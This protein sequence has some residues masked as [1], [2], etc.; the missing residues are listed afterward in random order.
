[1]GKMDKESIKSEVLNQDYREIGGLDYN[2]LSSVPL[3]LVYMDWPFIF[4]EK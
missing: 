3:R 4:T 1:M 2:R